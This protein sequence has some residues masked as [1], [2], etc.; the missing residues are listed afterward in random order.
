V[1]YNIKRFD[2]QPFDELK[3]FHRRQLAE[4]SR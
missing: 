3:L 4:L 1:S 2:G